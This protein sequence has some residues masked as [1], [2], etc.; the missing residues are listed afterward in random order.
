L[1]ARELRPR[2]NRAIRAYVW[3]TAVAWAILTFLL[4]AAVQ[5]RLAPRAVVVVKEG[6]VRYGPL[7]E[8]KASYTLQDGSEVDVLDS[9]DGWLHV[10]DS[11]SRAGWIRAEQIQLL[12]RP[13]GAK[14][15]S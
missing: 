11:G 4:V 12:N 6:V 3:P 9:K 1:T 14:S 13:P 7:A 8:S 15:R 5:Q 2:W 10:S